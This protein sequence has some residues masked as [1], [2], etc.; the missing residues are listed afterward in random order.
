MRALMRRIELQRRHPPVEGRIAIAALGQDPRVQRVGI[1]EV[2][3]SG[4]PVGGHG[5]GG[6]QLP[7]TTQHLSQ[8]Q[9]GKACGVIG[10]LAGQRPDVVI[11]DHS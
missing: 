1:R 8:V 11:H 4:Q 10:Q 5:E 2:A 6:I 9:K 7:A 3:V